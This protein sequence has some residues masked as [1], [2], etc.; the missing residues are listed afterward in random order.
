MSA[1][2]VRVSVVVDS[3]QAHARHCGSLLTELSEI[4]F[5]AAMWPLSRTPARLCHGRAWSM[6]RSSPSAG[7]SGIRCTSAVCSSCCTIRSDVRGS[8][9]SDAA[10]IPQARATTQTHSPV[11]VPLARSS[12]RET[13]PFGRSAGHLTV[14]QSKVVCENAFHAVTPAWDV[15]CFAALRGRL[16]V[17][18]EGTFLFRGVVACSKAACR[19][20]IAVC[21]DI[22]R[23]RESCAVMAELSGTGCAASTVL[24]GDFANVHGCH[25]PMSEPYMCMQYCV[26]VA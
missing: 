4:T 19:L 24:I 1:L 15:A 20:Y 10:S 6:I 5:A 13:R 18:P 11:A 22:S 2:G 8:A 23:P 16:A 3:T 21:I 26:A 9:S 14:L 25:L 17:P 7:H 12:P